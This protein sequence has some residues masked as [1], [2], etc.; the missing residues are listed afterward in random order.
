MVFLEYME[1]EFLLEFYVICFLFLVNLKEK[2]DYY[3]YLL[4]FFVFF[5]KVIDDIIFSKLNLC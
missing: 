5:N 3:K 1:L 4:F 2:D